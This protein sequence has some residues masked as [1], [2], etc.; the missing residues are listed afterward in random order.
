LLRC[1]TMTRSSHSG[2]ELRAL[3]PWTPRCRSTG[4][5]PKQ[6]QKYRAPRL[7]CAR[8]P[9]TTRYDPRRLKWRVSRK[10]GLH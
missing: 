1:G 9:T 8:S 2:R 4:S 3:P 7:A 10:T 5:P 6:K